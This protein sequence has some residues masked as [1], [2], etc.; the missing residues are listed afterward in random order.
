MSLHGS[1]I[2]FAPECFVGGGEELP[3]LSVEWAPCAG[4]LCA[5]GGVFRIAVMEQVLRGENIRALTRGRCLTIGGELH[6]KVVVVGAL[7]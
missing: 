5:Y 2:A 6:E 4:T 1:R 3:D 7:L